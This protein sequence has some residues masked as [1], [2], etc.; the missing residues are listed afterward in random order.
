MSP[1]GGAVETAPVSS[2]HAF[3]SADPADFAVPSGR[4]EE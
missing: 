1:L 4:E 2:L 3:R